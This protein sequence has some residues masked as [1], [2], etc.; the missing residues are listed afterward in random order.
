MEFLLQK[1]LAPAEIDFGVVEVRLIGLERRFGLVQ[2]C[3]VG[4]WIEVCEQG[5]GFGGLTFSL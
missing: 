5:S 1:G 2:R 3:L 4:P